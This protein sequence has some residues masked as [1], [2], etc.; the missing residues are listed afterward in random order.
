V[1][2]R[3]IA[4]W[5]TIV[6]ANGRPPVPDGYVEHVRELVAS[7]RRGDAVEY[8]MTAAAGL[9]P[10]FVAPMRQMPM[11]PGMEAIAHTIAYDGEVVQDF[12]AGDE[13][14][15]SLDVP[16][17]LL[18]GGTIPHLTANA[19]ALAA[20]LPNARRQTLDG[21]PHNV[22]DDAIAPAMAAFFAG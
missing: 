3:K 17:L 4:L 15:R 18:D 16:A 19:E 13:R 10:E 2:F 7:D 11:W 12:S 22:A 6:E 5:E 14:L 21:Q 20:A 1:P 9:P 8:F